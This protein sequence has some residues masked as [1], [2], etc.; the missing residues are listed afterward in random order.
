MRWGLFLEGWGPCASGQLPLLLCHKVPS[1][2]LGA[3]P[4]STSGCLPWLQNLPHQK[5]YISTKQFIYGKETVQQYIFLKT[6]Q[7]SLLMERCQTRYQK[8][9]E[10]SG[11]SY[12][13]LLNS[14]EFCYN[15]M[16]SQV[17]LTII[18]HVCTSWKAKKTTLQSGLKQVVLQNVYLAF[19]T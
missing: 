17:T 15:M 19:S 8:L 18:I 5:Q 7:E 3:H 11:R 13:S 16:S 14:E 2:E 4:D 6:D 12:T 9:E 1:N 10:T